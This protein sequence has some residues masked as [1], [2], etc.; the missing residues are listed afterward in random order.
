MDLFL[1]VSRGKVQN[2]SNDHIQSISE[3]RSAFMIVSVVDNGVGFESNQSFEDGLTIPKERMTYDQSGM[4]E[5]SFITSIQ[6]L[7]S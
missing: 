7:W 2:L 3:V 5:R 1:R 4:N 6:Q